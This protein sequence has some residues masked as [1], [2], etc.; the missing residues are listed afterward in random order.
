MAFQRSMY[1]TR[2]IDI[3]PEGIPVSRFLYLTSHLTEKNLRSSGA[4]IFKGSIGRST[5]GLSGQFWKK[6][7]INEYVTPYVRMTFV[8]MTGPLFPMSQTC[9]FH[10]PVDLWTKKP[11]IVGFVKQK[12]VRT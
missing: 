2:A 8:T 12:P 7:I 3:N 4:H 11:R 10:R 1:S 9:E 5:F 6:T